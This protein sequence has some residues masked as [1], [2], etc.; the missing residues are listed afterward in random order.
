[1]KVYV[2]NEKPETASNET[3]WA[4]DLGHPL[5]LERRFLRS[6]EREKVAQPDEG[7][8]GKSFF[9]GAGRGEV[10]NPVSQKTAVNTNL[11]FL[12]KASLP[13][14]AIA[15]RRL[16]IPVEFAETKTAAGRRRMGRTRQAHGSHRPSPA[17][18]GI[19]VAA[20]GEDFQAPC[21]SSA[22]VPGCE[23]GW[24][25]A[26]SSIAGR[27]ARPTRWRD[28]CAK[29]QCKQT[30]SPR[31]LPSANSKLPFFPIDLPGHRRSIGG[32]TQRAMWL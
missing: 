29:C 13:C 27:D 17:G 9:C 32:T 25:L 30:C 26:A 28:A 18:G 2:L 31:H 21:R 10:S 14:R 8:W 5:R 1:M 15:Q 11:Q 6:R 24:R 19:L 23:C 22:A 7:Q 12:H 4:F 16:V 20:S 3:V